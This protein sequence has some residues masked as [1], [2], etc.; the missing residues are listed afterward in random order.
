MAAVHRLCTEKCAFG[1]STQGYY[2]IKDSPLKIERAQGR[3]LKISCYSPCTKGDLI[4][5][6]QKTML[7]VSNKY[8]ISL[9]MTAPHG[10]SLLFKE[11]RV[12]G[13]VLNEDGK[14]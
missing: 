1:C 10:K 5:L 13:M 2:Y 9:L 12:G 11:Q 4:V 7:F 14:I 3:R 6:L 8:S